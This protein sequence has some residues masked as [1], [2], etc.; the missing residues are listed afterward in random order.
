M[1][2]TMKRIFRR[3]FFGCQ[4]HTRQSGGQNPKFMGIVTLV[5]T[6]VTFGGVA[7]AQQSKKVFRIGYLTGRE[8][9]NRIAAFRQGLRVL[10]YIEG[11]HIV[12]EYRFAE[13][14]LD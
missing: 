2:A 3:R 4:S 10:G 14:N 1:E 11:Q 13:G 12:I 9:P 5:L 8:S 6:F 7:D